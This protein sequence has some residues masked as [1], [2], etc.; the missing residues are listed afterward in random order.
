MSG[1]QGA[2]QVRG[3]LNIRRL[4]GMLNS[5]MATVEAE[6][7]AEGRLTGWLFRGGGW[8]HGVGMCQTGAIGRAEAGQRYPEILRFYFN[9]AEVAPIY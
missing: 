8:G 3:E 6:R 1:T 2:T 9:G 4:F 7:D 5:S